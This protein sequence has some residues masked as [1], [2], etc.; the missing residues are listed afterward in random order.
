MNVGQIIVFLSPPSI[1]E[2][3]PRQ[4]ITLDAST[5]VQCARDVDRN[6]IYITLFEGSGTRGGGPYSV[7]V[8]HTRATD[9]GGLVQELSCVFR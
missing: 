4:R 8:K 2:F 7:E 6:T 9:L 1:L 3:L 5:T